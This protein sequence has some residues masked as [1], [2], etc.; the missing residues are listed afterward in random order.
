MKENIEDSNQSLDLEPPVEP[1]V[2]E[3]YDNLDYQEQLKEKQKESDTF[4]L[5]LVFTEL[6]WTEHLWNYCCYLD[7]KKQA[8]QCTDWSD[9]YSIIKYKWEHLIIKVWAW[10]FNEDVFNTSWI[11]E[12]KWLYHTPIPLFVVNQ[13]D[14][15][16]ADKDEK[17]LRKKYPTQY[18]DKYAV[19]VVPKE[20]KAKFR[21]FKHQKDPINFDN[22]NIKS[23][24]ETLNIWRL[25]ILHKE[26]PNWQFKTGQNNC[27]DIIQK[28]QEMNFDK[29]Y[30]TVRQSKKF[31]NEE[32]KRVLW[33]FRHMWI[34]LP[35]SWVWD[36]QA[37]QALYDLI[38]SFNIQTES[39]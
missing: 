27:I 11:K 3:L 5:R 6:F 10:E 8:K 16:L 33:C 25:A 21:W 24:E 7:F 28:F 35:W 2:E 26:F 32:M 12:L 36:I 18:L 4:K 17:I 15:Y 13:I 20:W 29:F 39:F 9:L 19:I 34:N 37:Y 22:I 14:G 1:I 23:Y 31:L 30:D 38:K